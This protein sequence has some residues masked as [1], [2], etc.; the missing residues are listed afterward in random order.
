MD[1]EIKMEYPQERLSIAVLG[2]GWF[3]QQMPGT[4]NHRS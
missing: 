3:M 1:V 2:C 4:V